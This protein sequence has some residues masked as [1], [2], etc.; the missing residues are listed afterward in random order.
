[1]RSFRWDR[2]SCIH[3]AARGVL[4]HAICG[5]LGRLAQRPKAILATPLGPPLLPYRNAMPPRGSF[6]P[7]QR[8]QMRLDILFCAWPRADRPDGGLCHRAEEVAPPLGLHMATA[9][10]GGRRFLPPCALPSS[11]GSIAPRASM[12]S[13]SK[14]GPP[15]PWPCRPSVRRPL[16]ISAVARRSAPEPHGPARRG[17]G[18]G[19]H[20]RRQPSDQ[21]QLAGLCRRGHP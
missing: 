19:L 21:Y 18:S 7:I 8:R 12:Q 2:W 20:H 6:G 14:A 9:F 11:A 3:N 17:A 13:K 5:A 1:M 10:T 15:M 4:F 16:R